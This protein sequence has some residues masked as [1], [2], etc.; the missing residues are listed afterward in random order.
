MGHIVGGG[1]L[2]IDPS[3]VDV[4]INWPN[5]TTV[6]EVRSFLGA[7]QY[8]TRFIANF[9]YIAYPLHAL[10]NVKQVF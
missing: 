10:T 6:I 1:K 2:K 4:T 7:I 9:S 8:W 3:K 5:H